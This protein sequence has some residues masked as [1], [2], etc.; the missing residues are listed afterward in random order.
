[1]KFKKEISIYIDLV[2]QYEI[3][4]GTVRRRLNDWDFCVSLLKES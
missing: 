3:S 1:M 4:R 2:A